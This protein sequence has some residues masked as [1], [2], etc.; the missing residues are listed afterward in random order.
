MMKT[1]YDRMAQAILE[2]EGYFEGSISFK[3]KNPGNVKAAGQAGIVSKDAFGHAIFATFE[4]GYKAL[5]NQVWMMF[6]NTSHVYNS[7]MTLY[8]VFKHYAEGNSKEYAEFVAKRLDVT[9]ETKLKD[10]A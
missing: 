8:D 7:E 3:N 2:F 4:D 5:Y 6:S 10:I 9:P 1:V